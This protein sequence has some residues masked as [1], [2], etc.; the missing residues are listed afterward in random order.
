MTLRR[1]KARIV[2]SGPEGR[3]MSKTAGRTVLLALALFLLL[4]VAGSAQGEKTPA[5]HKTPAA[6]NKSVRASNKL[7][8][9]ALTAVS[10]S[11]AVRKAAAEISA[12]R[13]ALKDAG[14]NPGKRTD[15]AVQEFQ[16]NDSSGFADS[17]KDTF[18]LKEH[19]KSLLKN[20]HGSVYGATASGVGRA[21]DVNGDVGADSNNG[22]FSIFVQGEHSHVSTPPPH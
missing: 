21:N 20:I 10:T 11:D 22:K 1:I 5:L 12:K 14:K 15:N 7:P 17:S 9:A 3:N 6:N 19:K 16:I 8:L 2:A 4:P 18:H 13:L